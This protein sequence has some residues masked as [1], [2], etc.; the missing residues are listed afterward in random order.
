MSANKRCTIFV[1]PL[2][3]EKTHAPGEWDKVKD[4]IGYDTR[5]KR[6]T[7]MV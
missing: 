2:I 4:S 7:H 3:S 1:N 6:V 5:T